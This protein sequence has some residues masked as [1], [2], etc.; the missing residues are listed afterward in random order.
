[1]G[2]GATF[3]VGKFVG[4]FGAQLILKKLRDCPEDHWPKCTGT[5]FFAFVA[6]E[7][8]D[9]HLSRDA[10]LPTCCGALHPRL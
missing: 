5:H 7:L 8:A 2:E 3:C 6:D 10:A 1:M 9:C 4:A